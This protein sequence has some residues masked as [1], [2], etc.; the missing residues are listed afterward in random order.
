MAIRWMV[1]AG[2]ERS[3]AIEDTEATRRL[4]TASS[5][6]M[7]LADGE[8]SETVD[9]RAMHHLA[10]DPRSGH[11]HGLRLCPN[12][13]VVRSLSTSTARATRSPLPSMSRE[14]ADAGLA[15][16][17]GRR[18]EVALAAVC[19]AIG[20]CAGTATGSAGLEPPHPNAASSLRG[21]MWVGVTGY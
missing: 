10:T 1:G 13:G 2:S 20:A 4:A 6:A 19:V 12:G 9:R 16:A 3:L 15:A 7:T 14:G 18:P 5:T 8:S 21:S 17:K 11:R